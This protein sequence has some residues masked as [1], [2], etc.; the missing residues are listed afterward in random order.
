LH[1]TAYLSLD[2]SDAL[3]GAWHFIID[4][5]ISIINITGADIPAVKQTLP[6]LAFAFTDTICPYL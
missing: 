2:I 3:I 4:I 1:C 6:A 5:H